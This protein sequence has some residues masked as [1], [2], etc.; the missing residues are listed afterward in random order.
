[1]EP[2]D[3]APPENTPEEMAPETAAHILNMMSAKRFLLSANQSDNIMVQDEDSH[4]TKNK[5][6]SV[7]RK[8]IIPDDTDQLPDVKETSE[9]GQVLFKNEISDN[10]LTNN[11][12]IIN[13]RVCT[14]T[15]EE[16]VSPAKRKQLNPQFIQ[17]KLDSDLKQN[18]KSSILTTPGSTRRKQKPVVKTDLVH[19]NSE[20]EL[21]DEAEQEWQGT[22][23]RDG[24]ENSNSVD[25]VEN[26]DIRGKESSKNQ[27]DTI[28]PL[29][30]VELSS[31]VMNCNP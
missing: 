16:A 4:L 6:K 5:R 2:S 1:M 8:S 21:Q 13:K 7:P 17:Y 26:N 27:V 3:E 25:N 23:S 14:T 19:I 31:E 12:E 29:L 10:I 9:T 22:T 18:S 30:T 28:P 15:P 24:M 11:N 20:T